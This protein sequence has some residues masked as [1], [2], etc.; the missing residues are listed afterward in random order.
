[1]YPVGAAFIGAGVVLVVMHALAPRAKASSFILAPSV[2]ARFT[3]L[4]ASLPF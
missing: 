3:G 1:M 2:G 4:D